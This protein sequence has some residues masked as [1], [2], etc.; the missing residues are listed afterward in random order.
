MAFSANSQHRFHSPLTV[1]L[2]ACVTIL[3]VGL[4]LLVVP[5]K[6]PQ[7]E[8]ATTSTTTGSP[9]GDCTFRKGTGVTEPWASQICWLDVSNM[10]TPGHKARKIGDYTIEFDLSIDAKDSATKY[11]AEPNPSW[12]LS[13]FGKPGFFE[14]G[15]DNLK[16]VLQMTGGGNSFTRFTLD[17]IVV[18][19]GENSSPVSNYRFAVADAE[20]TGAGGPG[21]MISVDGGQVSAPTELKSGTGEKP[22]CE[23]KFGAGNE[24]VDNRWGPMADGRSRGF[25]CHSK[26]TGSH[27]SWIVGVD[28]PQKMQI[29]MGSF[30]NGTQAVA[31]GVA[32]SRINFGSAKDFAQVEATSEEKL[33]GQT[34]TASYTPF[35]RDGNTDTNLP[36]PENGYTTAMRRLDTTGTA[37]DRIGFRSQ[38][39]PTGKAFDRYD[40]VWTCT[41]SS[42]DGASETKVIKGGSVPDGYSLEKDTASGTSRLLLPSSE[43]RQPNCSV[44]WKSKFKPASLTL[45]K[46][47]EGSAANF[48]DVQLQKFTLHY[49]CTAPAGFTT[50]Y[51]D[52]KLEDDV[53]LE[54]GTNTVIDRLP[55]GASCTVTEKLTEGAQPS[56]GIDFSLSWN[57]QQATGNIDS[58]VKVDLNPAAGDTSGVV[59]GSAKALNKYDYQKASL[60]LSKHIL[61]EP[62]SNGKVGGTY[63]FGVRCEGTNLGQREVS[64]DLTKASPTNAVTI[65]DLPVGRD[66]VLTPLTDLTEQQRQTIKLDKRDGSLN[67]QHLDPDGNNGFHFTLGKQGETKELHFET[68]YSY[69]TSPLVIRKEITG[70][71]AGNDDL[72]ALSFDINYRCSSEGQTV[73]EGRTTIA[74]TDGEKSVGE[75]RIGAD[76]LVWETEPGDTT[77][78]H[79]QGAKVRASDASDKV[80]E[81]DNSAAKSQKVTTIRKV[82]GTD[83]NLVTVSNIYDPKLGTVDLHKVVDSQVEGVLP[84]SYTFTYRCGTRN[85]VGD[86]GKALPVELSGKVVVPADGTTRLE[87]DD[88]SLASKL[89]SQGGK[90]GVPYGN[91]CTFTEETPNVAGGI[92]F[93][94]DVDSAK[95]T[96]N[97]E[98]NTATVTNKFTAAGKGLTVSLRTGGRSTLAP[99]SLSY[100]LRC[101]NGYNT[102]FDLKSGDQAVIP[103]QKVPKGTNCSLKESGDSNKR[104]SESGNE[105]PIRNDSE[106]LYAAD[107]NEGND[108]GDGAQFTIGDQSTMD[109]HHHYDFVQA[110]VEDSK[111]VEFN[112]PDS[113]ISD[114]RRKIKSERVFPVELK[115]TNPDGSAGIDVTTTVQQGVQS[116][117]I[118]VNVGSD[119]T[120]SEGETTTAVGITLDKSINVNGTPTEGGTA[121][122]TVGN[123]DSVDVTFVNTYSR[124]TTYIELSKKAILP[125]DSIR[126]QYKNANK[127]LQDALYDHHFDLVC[128][129][130]ETGDEAVLQSQSGSIKGEG[131][132]T[133]TGVPVGADCQITGDHFG[134]LKLTMNDG[135]DD[136]NAYLRPAYVD[137]VVDRQGGNAYPDQKL[138]NEK[139]TSPA[140]LTADEP[141]DN[142]IRLD[143]HYEYETSK[144]KISKDLVGKDGNLKEIPEDYPFNFTMQCK[145]IGYQTNNIGETSFIPKK[146]RPQSSYILPSTLKKSEFNGTGSSGDESILSFASDEAIVPAGSYCRFAEEES[147]STPQTLRI[148]PDERTVTA[149]APAPDA[150]DAQDLH[151]VN[152]VERRTA[153]VKLVLSNFGYLVGADSQGYEANVVCK[154][155]ADSAASQQFPLASI[156]ATELSQSDQAPANGQTVELPVGVDCELELSG[157]ALQPRGELEVTNGERTPLTQYAKWS[158]GDREGA[159][160]SLSDIPTEDVSAENK[161]LKYSFATAGNLPSDKTELV[162]GVDI[163]HPRAHYDATFTKTADGA[164]G[165]DATFRFEHSCSDPAL[166][167]SSQ[168]NAFTLKAGQSYTI[169]NIPV[170][171]PCTV[172]EVD[173][174][175]KNNDSIFH[176][177]QHGDLIEADTEHSATIPGSLGKNGS[178]PI[179]PVS[180][181]VRPVTDGKD[182]SRSGDR[183]TLT[184]DNKFAGISVTK[185]IEGTPLGNLTGDLFG[186][187]LLPAE[188]E[189]MSMSYE[190]ANDGAYDLSDFRIQDASLAGLTLVKDGTSVEV[191][192]DGVVPSSVC[193][194]PQS[195]ARGESFTCSFDVVIPADKDETYRYPDSGQPE[196]KVTAQAS[197]DGHQFTTSASDSQGALRP[198]GLIGGLLP[199]TGMQTLVW[200]LVLG[201]ILLGFGLWRYLRRPDEDGEEDRPTGED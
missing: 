89:N 84:D 164:V 182:T 152:R 113:L 9:F 77:T 178:E 185:S 189:K 95:T 55:Q 8:A 34:R 57:G 98:N 171:S 73:S 175:V 184:A 153:P 180:F 92:I 115:C 96:V 138:D 17:N 44:V 186:T 112:D 21:E 22:A 79:F 166:S 75:V 76:C 196:V 108:I 130:P 172:N 122:F 3:L 176:I 124:R 51:P 35:L 7:A 140:F 62:V 85:I 169:K 78:T 139:T 14:K 142:K 86:N 19:R 80:T 147:S 56:A 149:Y 128:R 91:D 106:Y 199:E 105:Y 12:N 67:G 74:A 28:K 1:R 90:L 154:D 162:I 5:H 45:G 66:C 82:S 155:P 181:T 52:I 119:C 46:N 188:A 71:A 117:P 179:R 123:S 39:N 190:V 64:F 163:Y 43:T 170:N 49:K 47:V 161:N 111:Q 114:A 132:T 60:K 156:A 94:T 134:S 68:S 63:R 120:A 144:V 70:L 198:S 194:P 126:D 193:A 2:M 18:K 102:N 11:T 41:L 100:S 129:D 81:L 15:S 160:G 16:D 116:E 200:V 159:Q 33:S 131:K 10:T 27:A 143:N 183:W 127:D 54:R 38:T 24:P 87:S 97:A 173:D 135:S 23:L 110:S 4:A 53:K 157:P 146:L 6:E 93:S 151:F 36:A 109:V 99:E 61:G 145:A 37:Q 168:S 136:L 197:E 191:G 20:A 69:L 174:G 125:S 107:D 50:A 195:L 13:V 83:H 187:T 158:Q 31:L 118:Q 133:F 103:A 59:A 192:K 32:L 121:K 137:W 30:S 26:Q 72:K 48:S 42:S 201:L 165:K 167:D 177:S 58:P 150:S 40:P 88:P 101:D 141:N 148:T 104:T 65:S 29:S 25:V